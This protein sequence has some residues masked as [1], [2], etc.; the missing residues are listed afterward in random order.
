MPKGARTHNSGE[1]LP[2]T[3]E[4]PEGRPII[5]VAKSPSHSQPIRGAMGCSLQLSVAL[6]WRLR[7]GLIRLSRPKVWYLGSSRI[8]SFPFGREWRRNAEL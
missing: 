8:D 7:G 5:A 4:H 6:F 3:E 1:K 2:F